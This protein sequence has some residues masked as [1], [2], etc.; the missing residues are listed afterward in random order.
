MVFRLAD[1]AEP[2]HVMMA[3]QHDKVRENDHLTYLS[4]E[5]RKMSE[6]EDMSW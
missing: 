3:H 5:E 6:Q 4:Q 2:K 1:K